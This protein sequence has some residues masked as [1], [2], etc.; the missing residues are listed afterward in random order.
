MGRLKA[1]NSLVPK[2]IMAEANIRNLEFFLSRLPFLRPGQMGFVELL[3]KFG[4]FDLV[5]LRENNSKHGDPASLS[6]HGNNL[7]LAI[8]NVL[9]KTAA[10]LHRH[11]EGLLAA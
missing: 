3:T 2:G 8:D 5:R 1:E 11:G 6:D 9:S 4:N 10:R 7:Q